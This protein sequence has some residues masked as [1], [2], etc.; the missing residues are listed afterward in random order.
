ML[1][2]GSLH[3][4][5]ATMQLRLVEVLDALAGVLAAVHGDVTIAS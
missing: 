4:D 5:H 2:L 1:L 3:C